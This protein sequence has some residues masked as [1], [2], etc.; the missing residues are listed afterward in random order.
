MPYSWK[1]PMKFASLQ[2]LV[3]VAKGK[4]K[5][6]DIFPFATVTDSCKEANTMEFSHYIY[7]NELTSETMY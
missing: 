6:K 4:R 3:T 2:L 5:K 1:N 7:E